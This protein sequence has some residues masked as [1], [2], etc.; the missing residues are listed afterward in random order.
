MFKQF[1][2]RLDLG[3]G[4]LYQST[5]NANTRPPQILNSLIHST[6]VVDTFGW[7][8]SLHPRRIYF[9][10][11]NMDIMNSNKLDKL[12]MIIVLVGILA[13][14]FTGFTSYQQVFAQKMSNMTGM[15][16]GQMGQMDNMGGG[17]MGQ[18]GQKMSNMT[19]MG[20]GQMGQMGQMGNMGGGQMGQKISNM[21]GMG[22]GQMGQMG[23]M[24]MEGM[25]NSPG[26]VREMCHMGQSMPPH[27]CEPSYHVMTSIQGVRVSSVSPVGSQE[28]AVTLRELNSL[29]NGTTQKMVLVGGGGDLAGATLVNSGWKN[30]TT[31]SLKFVGTGSIYNLTG[32][33]I[34]LFPY[35][36]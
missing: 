33:H 25:D 32:L 26:A 21:T 20:G 7:C 2:I 11:F 14:I 13:A 23:N 18:M 6:N 12:G 29:S 1:R 8:H 24:M 10:L 31:A 16:G 34:H 3:K 9:G 5:Q 30:N 15:G 22:G 27:Y 28:I 4:E 35:T 36:Q 17:Q 19:G